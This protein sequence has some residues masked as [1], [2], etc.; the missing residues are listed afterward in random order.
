M[1]NIFSGRSLKEGEERGWEHQ[2]TETLL[3]PSAHSSLPSSLCKHLLFCLQWHDRG[4]T[5]R[6]SRSASSAALPQSAVSVWG[7]AGRRWLACNK[8]RCHWRRPAA[9]GGPPS[10]FWH[11]WKSLWIHYQGDR[12]TRGDSAAWRQPSASS[13]PTESERAL[14]DRPPPG[15]AGCRGPRSY[16]MMACCRWRAVAAVWMSSWRWGHSVCCCHLWGW[17]AA[18]ACLAA[19]QLQLAWPGGDQRRLL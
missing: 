10:W 13:A 19:P 15:R 16:Q 14:L 17:W 6:S 18:W 5:T 7:E 12:W 1:L 11:L 2:D 4:A 8:P 9:C 3:H